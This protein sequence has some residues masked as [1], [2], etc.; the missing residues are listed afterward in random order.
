MVKLVEQRKTW[1]CLHA[2]LA[3]WAKVPYDIV[4]IKAKSLEIYDAGLGEGEFKVLCHSF[5]ITPFFIDQ[6]YGG[7]EGVLILPSLNNPGEAH[8]V[9]LNNNDV[10]DPSN[11]KKYLRHFSPWPPCYQLAIDLNDDYGLEM[12]GEW[13]QF[14]QR[15]FDDGKP[16]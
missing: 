7:L 4:A 14:K 3:M 5:G 8:A 2:C 1:D 9:Y 15:L 11:K 6:A 10:Y 12:A 16:A 13:L